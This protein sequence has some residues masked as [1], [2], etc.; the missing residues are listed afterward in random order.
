[1]KRF[2]KKSVLPFVGVLSVCAFALPGV[3]SAAS[4]FVD[5]GG[6]FP[7]TTVLDSSNAANRLSFTTAAGAGSTCA[8]ATFDVDIRSSSDAIVTSAGFLNCM[9]TGLSV[10][11]TLT[12]APTAASLPWTITNTTT[13]NITIHNVDLTLHFENTPGNATACA[14]PITSRVTGNLE[15][16]SWSNAGREVTYTNA[17]GLVAHGI[18]G[19][20]NSAATVTG[21]LASTNLNVTMRD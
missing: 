21:T 18:P 17:P 9:G 8:V 19:A 20:P 13:T 7:A 1:M 10:N 6:A 3:A 15:N 5:P 14:T 4:W 16:G 2:S 11:C 12:A